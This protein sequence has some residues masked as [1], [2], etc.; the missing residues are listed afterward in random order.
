MG[1]NLRLTSP[2]ACSQN[3]S[4][5]TDQCP[6]AWGSHKPSKEPEWSHTLCPTQTWVLY[7]YSLRVW[8]CHSVSRQI[9]PGWRRSAFAIPGLQGTHRTR[10]RMQDFSPGGGHTETQGNYQSSPPP[11]QQACCPH[12][13]AQGHQCLSDSWFPQGPA[14]RP[15]HCAKAKEVLSYSSRALSVDPRPLLHHVGKGPSQFQGSEP[16]PG[17]SS[18]TRRHCHNYPAIPF[19]C[20]ATIATDRCSVPATVHSKA[21]AKHKT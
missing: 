1:G 19:K 12:S 20:T 10:N 13:G 9:K 11:C 6:A 5:G 17:I 21:G 7:A 15:A 3:L 2:S 18:L 4:R 8:H 16:I 14:A